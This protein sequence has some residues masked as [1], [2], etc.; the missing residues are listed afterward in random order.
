VFIGGNDLGTPSQTELYC[1]ASGNG[2]FIVRGF[3][4]ELFRMNGLLGESNAAI[5]KA[6][7]RGQPMT[8]DISL[9]VRGDKVVCSI[10][11]SIVASYDKTTLVGSGNLT[12]TN[13][14]AGLHLAGRF[15]D[16]VHWKG[17]RHTQS[18]EAFGKE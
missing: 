16:P 8:Q 1:A 12:S 11:G 3:G 15:Y 17:D 10:N 18:G 4:P 7:G 6:G 2:K 9:S 5:H 14:R 13:S